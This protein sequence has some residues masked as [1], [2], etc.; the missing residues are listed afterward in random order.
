MLIMTAKKQPEMR[1]KLGITLP[2]GHE[3]YI[4]DIKPNGTFYT[5]TDIR[6]AK[7]FSWS[8]ALSIQ[9]ELESEGEKV[10]KIYE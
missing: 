2:D 8:R 5:I 9:I 7:K 10:R 4:K 6:K 3:S 1:V